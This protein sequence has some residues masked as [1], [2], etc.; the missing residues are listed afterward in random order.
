MPPPAVSVMHPVRMQVNEYLYYNGVTRGIEQIEV[1]PR[2]QGYLKQINFKADTQVEKGELLFVIDQRPFKIALDRAQAELKGRQATAESARANVE[3]VKQLFAQG[4][5][6]EQELIDRQA[7]YDLALAEIGTAKAD[8]DEAQQNLDYTEVR[9]A[10]SGRVSRNLV[11][12][13]TLVQ[14]NSPVL[15][16]IVN[17]SEI[18]AIFQV[19]ESDFLRYI[20]RNPDSRTEKASD[21][22]PVVVELAMADQAGFP[23]TG[24]VVSGAN[25]VD[26]TT[27]TYEVRAQFPNPQKQIAAGLYV[28]LRAL[29][30]MAEATLVPDV[31]VQAD[32]RGTYV[33]VVEKNKDGVEVAI[34]RSV[35]VDGGP[36]IGAYRRILQGVAPEDKVVFNG[37]V[38]VRPEAPV[39]AAFDAPPAP[40]AASNATT[41][42]A[43]TQPVTQ[44][45]TRP[46]T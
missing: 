16:T 5:A 35:E 46:N 20:R 26:P 45:T 7:A 27:A 29:M 43:T 38:R 17:D 11:D 25:T 2:V 12:V 22:E 44:P 32:Q 13:G 42:P 9:A 10:I 30:G 34:R 6:S 1:R 31:A 39:Q 4:A 37:M 23:Q 33:Y 14:V 36:P 3:R 18:H 21:M 40:P 19:S 28:R 15:A 41:Q 8:L 24:R